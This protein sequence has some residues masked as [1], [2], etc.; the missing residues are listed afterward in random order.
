MNRNEKPAA[1]NAT[2]HSE[3][4]GRRRAYRTTSIV[5]IAVLLLLVL[6]F[7]VLVSV[8]DG[9]FNLHADMSQQK[10]FSISDTTKEILD[11]LDQDIYVYTLYETGNEDERVTELMRNYAAY[12]NFFH[13]ENVDPSLNPGFTAEFDPAGN[14]I[15]AGSM[16][17]TNESHSLFKVFNLF[18]LY[19][20]DPTGTYVYTFNAESRVSSAIVYLQTGVTYT[21]RLLAGHSE[22]TK[23]DLSELVVRL[24]GLNYE[25]ES[26]DSTV[27]TETLDPKY[28][29]LMVVSPAVDLT[30]SEYRSI[31]K[32]LQSG[33]NAI[34]MMD[35]VLFSATTGYTQIILDD[36][37]NFNSLLMMYGL[38]VNKD[39]V[40]GGDETRLYKRVTGLV[41]TLYSHTI[42]DPLTENNLVP[43]LMDCSSITIASGEN[44]KAG[45]LLESD[46]N[47]WAKQVSTSMVAS[48]E[49]G[50]ATGPFTI[51]AV[52]QNGD[53]KIAV[54]STSSFVLSNADGI[55][56][57]A[58]EALIVNTVNTL[59][60]NT[61]NLNI[62]AKSMMMGSMEFSNSTQ[63]LL[64]EILL[65]AVIPVAIIGFGFSVWIKRKRK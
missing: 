37:A 30:S 19:S 46:D 41:P 39:Y 61:S 17:V 8:L 29:L 31:Q 2:T 6:S 14:G 62:P 64:L 1:P 12:S 47:T 9:K 48:Y 40:I 22:F 27:S 33:G 28:D 7:N 65:I 50:D 26:Y 21:I 10:Y 52:A 56:R 35:Y 5:S 15:A 25:V 3:G 51:G 20:I 23:G 58:N 53:S 63:A 24:N 45:V 16:I 44:I 60:E 36:L 11:G 32:F 55:E 57:S 18:E 38:S 13:F 49:A 34:F 42:T 4:F 43:I 54:F 59:A